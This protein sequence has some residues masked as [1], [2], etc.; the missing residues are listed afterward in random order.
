MVSIQPQ[1]VSREDRKENYYSLRRVPRNKKET[2]MKGVVVFLALL[3]FYRR[4]IYTRKFIGR[5]APVA[6][7]SNPTIFAA[8]DISLDHHIFKTFKPCLS[9]LEIV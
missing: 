7:H 8:R 6:A 9:Y 5:A 3:G 1:A 2:I 4:G